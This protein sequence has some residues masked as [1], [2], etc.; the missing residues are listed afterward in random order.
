MPEK[1]QG[2]L[3]L[4]MIIAALLI[5]PL[6]AGVC[7][8]Y[9]ETIPGGPEIIYQD[10]PEAEVVCISVAVAAGSVYESAEIRGVTHF[11]EHLC[12]DGTERFSRREI[13][14]WVDDS[15]SFLNAFTRKE[16]TVY[17]MLTGRGHLE[18]AVEILS[19]M[20]LH[21][22][23]PSDEFEKEKKIVLEE[24]SQTIDSPGQQRA[25]F[26]DRYLYRGSSL[27]EPVLGYP[28]TISEITREQ[29]IDYYRKYYNPSR[30]RIT[31]TGGFD[32]RQVRGWVSDYFSEGT[33]DPVSGLRRQK[34]PGK[35]VEDGKRSSENIEYIS[36]P[37]WS[38]EITVKNS[39]EFKAGIEVLVPVPGM[40]EKGFS[41]LLLLEEILGGDFSP[42]K[43]ILERASLPQAQVSLEVHRGFSALRFQFDPPSEPGGNGSEL[44]EAIA[45][46]SS[47]NPSKEMLDGARTSFL[48]AEAANREKFHFYIMLEGERISL[49]GERYLS[50]ISEG[51]EKTCVEDIL[52]VL[53]VYFD[54]I[55]FNAVYIDD[56]PI[57]VS[58]GDRDAKPQ[59]RILDN[60]VTL[61]CSKRTGSDIAAMHI[62]VKG[63]SCVEEDFMPGMSVILYKALENSE[64]GSVLSAGMRSIG[65]SVQWSDNPYIP[66]DDYYLN[67]SWSFIRLEVPADNIEKAVRLVTDHLF[68]SVLTEE[69]LSGAAARLGRE[70]AVRSGS[71]SAGL[72][73]AVRKSLFGEHL[74]SRSVFPDPSDLAKV[75][76]DQLGLFRQ[77]SLCGSNL[78][79]SFVSPLDPVP[80]LARFEKAFFD[81][82][83]G[84]T[85]DCMP[86]R[87]AVAAGLHD[88]KSEKS[89][90]YMAAGWRMLDPSIEEAAAASVASELLSRRM[91]LEIRENRGLAYSAGASVDRFEG[92][93]MITAS[94]GT[95]KENLE[96]ATEALKKEILGLGTDPVTA[97]EVAIAKNRVISKLARRRLS[98][99][100][101]AFSIGF[102]IFLCGGSK[103]SALIED[104]SFEEIRSIIDDLLLGDQMVLVRTIPEEGGERKKMMPAGKMH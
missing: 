86:V 12:F 37:R 55:C 62:M 2:N 75:T 100:N 84:E 28:S 64:A 59:Q 83:P 40:G 14:G 5:L 49:F 61:A 48:S 1:F 67:P 98:S 31:V 72:W 101:K 70:L 6:S 77:K 96:E 24:I 92:A 16:T 38:N 102:D 30:M 32:R 94:L 22:V 15:G 80:A 53:N 60:G 35:R 76:I 7:K 69:D 26:I 54:P 71:A 25:R 44:I 85:R 34:P 11:L 89:G 10:Y 39:S 78:I 66:M 79:V 52:R 90:V 99:I 8:R 41:A 58:R 104:L 93:L 81:L 65:G 19:Q 29:V 56:R 36:R 57:Q 42:L 46:L 97:D 51:I 9:V 88:E 45:S 27:T 18:D 17:F 63:R 4:G 95:R 74:Y 23:F 50:A 91:Q 13:S 3:L 68:N 82:P 87:D 33:C 103:E 47:W 73:S 21:S 43:E 20:L